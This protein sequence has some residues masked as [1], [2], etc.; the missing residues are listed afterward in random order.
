MA[1]K[2]SIIVLLKS[3]KVV[4]NVLFFPEGGGGGGTFLSKTRFISFCV[5][6]VIDKVR[7][8]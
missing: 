7:V 5:S 2:M 8:S 1:K 3:Q 4:R 6:K